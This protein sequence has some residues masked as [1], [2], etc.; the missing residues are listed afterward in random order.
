MM[1]DHPTSCVLQALIHRHES[2]SRSTFTRNHAALMHGA[3]IIYIPGIPLLRSAQHVDRYSGF[4]CDLTVWQALRHSLDPRHNEFWNIVTDFVPMVRFQHAQLVFRL[5]LTPAWVPHWIHQPNARETNPLFTH[6]S[7]P[8]LSNVEPFSN[9]TDPPLL[10]PPSAPFPRK[11]FFAYALVDIPFS[12]PAFGAIA[13]PPAMRATFLGTMFFTAFQHICSLAAH[14]FNCCS[15]RISHMIWTLDYTAIAL[16]FV[17]N[18]PMAFSV[19]MGTGLPKAM[20]TAAATAAIASGAGEEVVEDVPWLWAWMTVNVL[21]TG[22]VLTAAVWFV[23]TVRFSRAAALVA[24]LTC[25]PV[26]QQCPSS[27]L[28]P[29]SGRLAL[30]SAAACPPP[31]TATTRRCHH[32]LVAA[33]PRQPPRLEAAGGRPRRAERVRAR[34]CHRA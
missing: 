13:T 1:G 14:T 29:F 20:T 18:A 28:L 21:F 2:H 8:L 4:R 30:L 7:P 3:P 10:L 31:P 11:A 34:L 25:G 16:N 17:W 33:I 24:S 22:P 5:S 27:S 26:V 19:A 23:T 9:A 12:D 6:C 32:R 15:P